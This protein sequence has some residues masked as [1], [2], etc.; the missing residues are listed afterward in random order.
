LAK[1]WRLNNPEK[2]RAQVERSKAAYHADPSKHRAY[3]MF[4]DYGIT[5]DQYFHF[6]AEQD[7]K[8]KLCHEPFGESRGRIPVIDHDHEGR[9]FRGILHSNCNKAI[10]MLQDNPDICIKAAEY[11]KANQG[12]KKETLLRVV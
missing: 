12:E 11:L 1:Q 2:Y 10:G 7:G 4:R 6:L 8:C 9:K 5:M 3:I